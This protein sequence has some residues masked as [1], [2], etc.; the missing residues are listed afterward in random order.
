MKKLLSLTLLSCSLLYSMS[1]SELN[2]A[3][4]EELMQIKGIGAKKAEEILKERKKNKFKS[5]DDVSKVKG[6]GEVLANNIK[7]DIKSG[8]ETKTKKSDAKLS[9]KETA[10]TTISSSSK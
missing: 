2:S 4:K 1:L 5:V 9:K 8:A 6:V 7:K 3:S 10:K